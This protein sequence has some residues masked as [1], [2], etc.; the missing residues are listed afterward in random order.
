MIEFSCSEML[1]AHVCWKAAID[2][3]AILDQQNPSVPPAPAEIHYILGRL[4][5]M[6]RKCQEL[7]LDIAKSRFGNLKFNLEQN[8]YKAYHPIII[9]L[10]DFYAAF[11]NDLRKRHFAYIPMEKG[12]FFEKDA[13]FG[14]AA[15]KAFPSAMHDIKDAGNCLA[16]DLHPAT[17]FHLM[18]V[19]EIGL[20]ELARKLRVTIPKTPLDYAGWDSVVRAIDSKLASKIPTARGPKKSAA[21]KF[22]QDLLS[23][24]KAFEVTRNE[25]MHCRWRC[26]EHEAMGLYIRVRDFIQRLAQHL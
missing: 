26:N 4:E 7:N 19:V 17:A 12:E 14:D 23:D 6:A 18:R 10:V 9:E 15:N 24:F 2:R 22:K 13:L 25:I 11:Q 1:Q 21:L 8:K 16:A 20:R 3:L 5:P